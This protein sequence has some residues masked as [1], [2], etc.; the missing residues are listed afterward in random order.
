MTANVTAMGLVASNEADGYMTDWILFLLAA[1]A[2]IVIFRWVLP[3]LG[4]PT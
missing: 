4:V 1:V 2:Y 3:R